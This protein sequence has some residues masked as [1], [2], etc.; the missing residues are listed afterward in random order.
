MSNG[1]VQARSVRAFYGCLHDDILDHVVRDAL[2][3]RQEAR[4]PARNSL[5][6][7]VE[8]KVRIPGFKN[9]L[10]KPV[11]QLAPEV[12]AVCLHDDEIAAA[13]LAV[14]IDCHPDLELAM[15]QF[16]TARDIPG[17][18][19]ACQE[20]ELIG[21]WDVKSASRLVLEFRSARPEFEA[22]DVDPMFIYVTGRVP[23]GEGSNL[24]G[25]EDDVLTY[26]GMESGNVANAGPMSE[27]WDRWMAQLRDLPADAP[28][29]DGV[30]A[31]VEELLRLAANKLAQRGSREAL[32][33]ALAALPID[34]LTYFEV[35]E[36]ARWSAELCPLT[37]C[38]DLAVLV[39]EL[40]GLLGEHQNLRLLP[41]ASTRSEQHQRD[42]RRKE[43][44]ARVVA[45]CQ[46][47][48]HHLS[49][50]Q[51][52]EPPPPAGPEPNGA[53]P[54]EVREGTSGTDTNTRSST[55]AEDPPNESPAATDRA[56]RPEDDQIA[57]VE[58]SDDGGL[59]LCDA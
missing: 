8:R 46:D 22:D 17:I 13:V 15:R 55:E 33:K 51:P 1:T 16:L 37:K 39:T 4:A 42:Q 38:T 43:I 23:V 36:P 5:E 14:W 19:P 49:P 47:L 54:V 56:Q 30:K 41:P 24:N 45:I 57:T 48:D 59:V 50:I 27:D 9:P 6:S 26:D 53:A 20:F 35:G 40:S 34:L 28:A 52:D 29:W 44:E 12:R 32:R 31:F 11:A 10:R 2:E 3:R 25:L 18:D 21:F 58:F 7:L